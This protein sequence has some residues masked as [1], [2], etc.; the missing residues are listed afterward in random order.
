MLCSVNGDLG[1]RND[2]QVGRATAETSAVR[3][4]LARESEER[5]KIGGFGENPYFPVF[6]QQGIRVKPRF[7]RIQPARRLPVRVSHIR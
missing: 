5:A 3:I 6:S 1:R 4:L 7:P 2:F